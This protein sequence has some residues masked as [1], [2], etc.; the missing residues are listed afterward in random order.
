MDL[1]RFDQLEIPL[2]QFDLPDAGIAG[3]SSHTATAM[4][5]YNA[6]ADASRGSPILQPTTRSPLSAGNAGA[7]GE[8]RL[9][10]RDDL[11]HSGYADI[12]GSAGLA[13]IGRGG[14]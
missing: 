2:R 13:Q 7:T 10:R 5:I 9:I 11:S 3:G 6:G 14:R 1:T 4:A 12:I 8:C